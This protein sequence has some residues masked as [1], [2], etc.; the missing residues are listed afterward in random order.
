MDQVLSIAL[1]QPLPDI[2]APVGTESQNIA[3]LPTSVD[4]PSAHQ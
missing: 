4:L 3:P 1:E 2:T